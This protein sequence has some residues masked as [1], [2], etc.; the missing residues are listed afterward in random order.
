MKIIVTG[1]GRFLDNENNPTKDI[2]KLLPK[3]ILG[4]EIFPIELPVIFDECFD[5]L[6][7]FI[8][9]IDPDVIIM[10][11]LAGGRKAITPERVA[12]NM[13]DTTGPDNIGYMPVDEIIDIN[14]KNAFFSGLPLR[15]IE[16]NLK[17]YNIPVKI[18]NSAGLYV[19]NN[20]MYK[21]LNYIDQ[22]NL[23]IKAGFVHVPYSDESKPNVDVFSL[24][25]EIIYQGVIEII[26]AVL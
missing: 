5:Y 7:P 10:L 22:N 14:G 8:V 21:V 24:P 25:I 16:K 6:K 26:K 19:C 9:D 12:I 4:N 1:F 3:T 2:L 15:E 20:I 13:K 18:S 17:I 11:G 23:N